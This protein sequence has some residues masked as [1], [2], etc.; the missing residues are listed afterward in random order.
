[1]VSLYKEKT[2]NGLRDFTIMH[3]NIANFTRYIRQI[4]RQYEMRKLNPV[5]KCRY[6]TNINAEMNYRPAEVTNLSE[7]HEPFLKMIYELYENGITR[8]MIS[9]KAPLKGIAL[10][11]YMLYD[12]PTEAGQTYTFSN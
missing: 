7:T 9:E 4:Y 6:T 11:P 10:K 8:P 5:W 1:M 3:I 2:M 12:I